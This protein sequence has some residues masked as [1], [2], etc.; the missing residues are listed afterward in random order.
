[1]TPEDAL[2]EFSLTDEQQ[3]VLEMVRSFAEEQVRPGAA[4]RDLSCEFPGALFRQMGE[5][6]LL[7]MFVPEEYGGSGMDGMSYILAVEQLARVDASVAVGMSVTN[8]VCCWPIMTFGTEDQKHRYLPPLAGGES[9]GGFMLTEPEA[10][11]DAASLSTRYRDAGDHWVLDGSKAWITNAGVGRTFVC[12]ATKDPNLGHRGISAFIVDADQEGVVVGTPEDKMGLRA[13]KTCMVNLE[14]AIVPKDAMLGDEG[15]GFLIALATLDHSR[16]GIAAQAI[17]I[18][19]AALEES[20]R[21]ARDR[22]QF[23]RAIMDHQAIAFRLADMDTRIA[24]AR[25]LLAAAVHA[26][27]RPGRHSHESARAK[28]FASEM[29]NQVVGWGVQIHG[30]YGYSREYT[31]ERLYRDAKVTTIYE[32]TSEVQ[33]MVIAKALKEFAKGL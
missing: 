32:G 22:R 30:G 27:D 3:M 6:G 29:C 17:G 21:Y 7:G 19:Q 28:L 1:M 12:M 24:A 18:A 11:S 33:K 2:M 23:G 26:Q 31:I 25:A 8:S 9:L 20:L 5:L 15:Q 14:G 4:A 10:G 16:L 13:S